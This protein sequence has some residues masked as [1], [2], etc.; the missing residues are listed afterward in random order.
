[1]SK[2]FR[3]IIF[4]LVA[5][6]IYFEGVEVYVCMVVVSNIESASRFLERTSFR[7]MFRHMTAFFASDFLTSYNLLFVDVVLLRDLTGVFKETIVY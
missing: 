7:I 6:L 3:S 4:V 2:K 1:M 5:F